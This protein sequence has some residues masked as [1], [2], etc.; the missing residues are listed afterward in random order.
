MAP[1]LFN[2]LAKLR[3]LKDLILSEAPLTLR[4]AGDLFDYLGEASRRTAGFVESF[5][6]MTIPA[7]AAGAQF[8]GGLESAEAKAHLEELKSLQR[9]FQAASEKANQLVEQPQAGPFT[10][11]LSRIDPA[12]KAALLKFILEMM[13]KIMIKAGQEEPPQMATAGKPRKNGSED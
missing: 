9:E 11:I 3:Q 12:T 6:D 1:S 5:G 8:G 7:G 13:S 4:S 10:G 2:I